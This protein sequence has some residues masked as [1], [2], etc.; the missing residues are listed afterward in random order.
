MVTSSHAP[1]ILLQHA[2]LVG[3]LE[4][5]GPFNLSAPLW[6]EFREGWGRVSSNFIAVVV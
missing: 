6:G 4:G 2:V 1:Q 5:A 3:M